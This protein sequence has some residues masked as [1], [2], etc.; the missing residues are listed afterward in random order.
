MKKNFDAEENYRD[1]KK[2]TG[3]VPK[4]KAV[5]KTYSDLGF[6]SGLEIHQQLKTA[7]KL[8]CRCPAGIYHDSDD[9]NAEVIRHMRPTLSELGEYDG[10]ALMEFKTKKNITYRINNK[11]ACTYEIDDTP[12]FPLNQEALDIA[13][14]IALILETNIVGELHITRKQYLDG[15]IPTG[16]QRTAIV[17]IEGEIPL[18]NKKIRIIQLGI[19]EES[20]REV[21]DIGHERI[22]TTDRLGIPLIEAVTYP[23][24][25]TPDEAA[26]AGHYL[27][28]L[29]RSTGKVRTGIGAAREDVNVSIDG[30]TRVEIK[31]VAHIAWIPLLTHI[32]AFRQKA[33]LEIKKILVQRF[34]DPSKWKMSHKT[35]PASLRPEVPGLNNNNNRKEKNLWKA[36][37]LPGFK[38]ILSF[39]TQPGKSFAN[40][41]SDRLK[42]IACIEKPNLIHSEPWDKQPGTDASL[43]REERNLSGFLNGFRFDFAPLRELLKNGENDAQLIIRGP[44]ADIKTALETIAERCL[45]AFADVPV[46]NETRKS[47]PDGSTIFERVLPGPN[48]MYPD[49][50]SPPISIAEDRIQAIRQKLPQQVFLSM[51]Q[52]KEWKIPADAFAYILSRNLYPLIEKIVRDFNQP[53]V[54]VGTLVGHRLKYIEGQ[55]EPSAP[56]DY[57]RIYELFAF[58]IKKELKRDILKKMLPEVYRHPNKDFDTV[59]T[60]IDFKPAAEEKI[61]DNIPV[62]MD[63]FFE[64]SRLKEKP[65]SIRWVMG[66]LRPIALGNMALKE[67]HGKVAAAAGGDND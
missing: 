67:L 32:E 62:L 4:N 29:T 15:S 65:A 51:K 55:I 22:Y 31:G 35:L 6:K 30:G 5:P 16:F 37:N 20:C 24:M 53:A 18:T 19:E 33:L 25:L 47:F 40:E 49:T 66:H 56:F 21:S 17:G 28:F 23:D 10:T 7:K 9:F 59:L 48:R 54:F 13:I 58:I 50:D 8:F 14:E 39:F 41:I 57:R 3:Y 38:G 12:P 64:I 42:V 60:G 26:E 11:T 43:S 61:L 1:T 27:R 63:K 45:L 2:I 44:K 34:P 52:M 46:P 36:V